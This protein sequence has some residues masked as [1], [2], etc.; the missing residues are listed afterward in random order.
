M[1]LHYA[2]LA[3]S[4]NPAFVGTY[5]VRRFAELTNPGRVRG[6]REYFR[7][8]TVVHIYDM[9]GHDLTQPDTLKGRQHNRTVQTDGVG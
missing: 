2:V 5:P 7:A 8:G 9:L 4:T 1:F 6:G 3:R